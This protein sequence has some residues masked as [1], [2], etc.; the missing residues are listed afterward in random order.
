MSVPNIRIIA[1]YFLPI[2]AL[3]EELSFYQYHDR[4]YSVLMKT[5]FEEF[6]K[7]NEERAVFDPCSIESLDAWILETKTV[8][9]EKYSDYSLQQLKDK[10]INSSSFLSN[11]L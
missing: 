5:I 3:F 10:G 2:F 6:E 8:F 9:G 1:K 4:N 11:C 7:I